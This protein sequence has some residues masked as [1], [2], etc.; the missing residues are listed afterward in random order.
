MIVLT[1]FLA[2]GV[3]LQAAAAPA[4][5]ATSSSIFT[6][7]ELLGALGVSVMFMILSG[8][9]VSIAI[10]LVIFRNRLLSLTHAGWVTLLFVLHAGFFLFYLRG[11]AVLSS[12]VLLIAVGVVCVIAAAATE[13]LVWRQWL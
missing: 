8:Y 5:I 4:A 2:L 10:L 11:P 9:L 3:F 1:A 6:I 13:Y 12:S 7:D